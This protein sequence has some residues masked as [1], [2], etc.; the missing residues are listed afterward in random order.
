[1]SAYTYNLNWNARKLNGD[2]HNPSFKKVYVFKV[3][4]IIDL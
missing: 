2:I 1:M 4:A 3:P